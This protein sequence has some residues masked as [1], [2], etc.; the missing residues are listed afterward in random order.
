MAE[1]N[2][3]MQA[4][5]QSTARRDRARLS[6]I[7]IAQN[8][9]KNLRDCLESV[10]WADEIIVVDGGS[11]DETI[12]IAREFTE[13]VFVN[14]WPGYARQK[15]FA[16]DR[17][18]MEWVLSIDA[19]ERVTPELRD[20]ILSKLADGSMKFSAYEIPR[21]STFLGKFIYHSGW[22][23]GYQ[24]R[25]FRRT[26]A[27][28]S[29]AQ[30]HEGFIVEGAVGR[31]KHHML[32]FTHRSLEESFERL[33]RYSGLEAQDRL[34]RKQVRWWDL[35]THPVSAF[36]NKFIAL[37]GYRDGMHGFVLALITAMVKMALYMKIWELQI[38]EKNREK[39][40]P[41]G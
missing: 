30:V 25:L 37:R 27:R 39:N 23:P 17:A 8:E 15:Q 10:R 7:L 41:E 33:N 38:R 5:R 9:E 34:N 4:S 19:D 40:S 3:D 6:V 14:P 29:D 1:S 32:H 20:E 24:L 13:H 31:L 26:K 22:Y 21:L 2:S 18:R 28:L 12:A 16:L 35:L 11:T 36:F